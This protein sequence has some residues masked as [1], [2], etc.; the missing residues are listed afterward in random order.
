MINPNPNTGID[1]ILNLNTESTLLVDVP[2][3]TNAEMPPSS[4]TTL[5]PPPIS[6]IQPLQQT[7]VPTP[8]MVPSTSLQNLP[9]FSSV[10]KF[11]VEYKK[12]EKKTSQNSAGQ[13]H[14]LKSSYI[15][16]GIVD[17]YL[18]NQMN[19][20]VKAVVQLQSDRLREAAQAEK[21]DFINK[22]DENIKKIIKEQVKEALY[23]ALVDAYET[24][25]GILET[26]G[27]TI[28][29]KRCQDNEDKGEEPS[30]GSNWGSKRRRARKEPESTSAPNE[31][32][33]KSNGKSKEGSKSH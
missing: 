5:P 23:K 21:Q 14:L 31:K 1:F 12:L 13:T 29:F 32:T 6:F 30:T 2:V 24:D 8:I 18:A 7:P 25:K 9:T 19:E 28:T 15:I 33:S 4:V 27:D 26:Y 17:K 10:F 22:I 11:I 3:M 20:A 16:P